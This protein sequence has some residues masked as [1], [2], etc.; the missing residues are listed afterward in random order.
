MVLS[1]LSTEPLNKQMI[2]RTTCHIFILLILFCGF[3]LY[4]FHILYL[5]LSYFFVYLCFFLHIS[6]RLF[7]PSIFFLFLFS[8]FFYFYPVLISSILLRMFVLFFPAQSFCLSN[9]T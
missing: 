7:L 3:Y 2:K 6:L 8:L 5:S 1:E 9:I 4:C